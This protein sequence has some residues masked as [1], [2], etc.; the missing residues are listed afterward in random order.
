MGN[1]YRLSVEYNLADQVVGDNGKVAFIPSFKP[2]DA[3]GNLLS[4]SGGVAQGSTTSG[5]LG[6]LTQAAVTTG[7]PTYTTA[8]TS[9][10][11]LTTAGD[12]RIVFSNTTIAA[13]QATASSLNA[14]VVGNVADSAADSGNPAK[15]GGVYSVANSM[16]ALTVGNRGNA[17]MTQ[18][19]DLRSAITAYR[20]A[21][22]DTSTTVGWVWNNQANTTNQTNPLAT[23]GFFWNGTNLFTARGD[24]NGG[25]NQPYAIASS[26]WQYA[27]A[28]GGIS[29]T[30][31][32]VTIAAAAGAA[33]RNYIT[34]IQIDTTAL[35]AA[36]EIVVRDGAAGTVIWRGYIGTAGIGNDNI[37][38]PV[39]LKGTA[40]TLL[41][42]A[43]LTATITG[44]VYFNAQGFTGA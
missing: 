18:Y 19:G 4:L 2:T 13:T 39:P 15:I 9:P 32:A 35:G 22:N 36:T 34:A 14:Q 33:I 8:Q 10:L 12:L 1:L 37:T 5:Q 31:T 24:A 23:A 30:T 26:R 43:T 20:A 3:A 41:E 27:A 29:N 17:Q 28:A 38:F 6:S 11:S 44:A 25:V 7:A 40:N 42:V 16:T 21:P